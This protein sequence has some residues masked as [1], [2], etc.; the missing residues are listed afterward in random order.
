MATLRRA[1]T[2]VELLIVLAIILIIAGVLLPVFS[3]AKSYSQRS[4]CLSNLK[5]VSLASHLYWADYDDTFA[6]VNHQPAEKPNSR[7][8][9]TWVQ[10]VLPYVHNF[11][12]FFC[13][14]D[15]SVK[16]QAEAS[17]DSD[18]VPGDTDSQYYTASQHANT[19]YNF[20]YLAPIVR[21]DGGWRSE[22]RAT[23]V[24]VNP[25]NTV[26]FADSVWGRGQDGAPY[27]GGSW[28][29]VP[30]CRYTAA[31]SGPQLIDTFTEAQAGGSDVYTTADGWEVQDD[32]SAVVYGGVWPWH[33]GRVNVAMVDGSVHSMSTD[34]LSKGCDV[35]SNWQGLI[36]NLQIYPW[37]GQ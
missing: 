2:L 10:L 11:R 32:T 19:G 9:R 20:Q 35:Q 4:V 24:I 7:N 18:L 14:S 22:P 6:L 34:D 1:F 25:S 8:D 23:T 30:P 28:L 16:P 17:F 5:Q 36:Q 33:L 31:T 27:G 37:A 15:T 3:V 13:P 21:S 26:L 12:I 29:V